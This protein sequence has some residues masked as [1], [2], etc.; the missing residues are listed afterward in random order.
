[1]INTKKGQKNCPFS[2]I[3]YKC[4]Y[5]YICTHTCVCTYIWYTIRTHA[6]VCTY[7]QHVHTHVCVRTHIAGGMQGMMQFQAGPHWLATEFQGI[8]RLS[9]ESCSESHQVMMPTGTNGVSNAASV[10]VVGLW[11]GLG[12]ES[13][14]NQVVGL[15]WRG[16][17]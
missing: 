1:M 12:G 6:C 15:G 10:Q 4:L 7:I 16:V 2:Y 11:G 17:Y 14:D 13:N 8:E 3:P 9:G 5:I